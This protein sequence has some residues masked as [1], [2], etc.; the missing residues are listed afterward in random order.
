[1]ERKIEILKKLQYESVISLLGIYSKEFKAGTQ[2][3]ICTYIW[4]QQHY[5]QQPKDGSNPS[6]H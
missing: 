2:A 6:V 3:N 5:S 4:P 1:M